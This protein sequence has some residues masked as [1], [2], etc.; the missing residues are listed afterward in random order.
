MLDKELLKNKLGFIQ[1]ELKIL[2]QYENCS[3]EEIASDYFK[4]AVIERILERIINDALDINQHI[5]SETKGQEPPDDYKETFLALA[6]IEIY[7]KEFAEKISKSVGLRNMLVHNYRKLDEEKFYNSI[8]DCLN[9]Y[10]KYC[11]Y[12]LNFIIKN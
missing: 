11:E 9:D 1:K 10:A 3:L 6:I 5:I 4:H 7:P 2:T 8:K 12:I